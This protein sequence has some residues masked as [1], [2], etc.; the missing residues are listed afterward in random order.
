M[1]KISAFFGILLILFSFQINAQEFS[2]RIN[3]G[4]SEVDYNDEIYMVDAH[5]DTGSTLVRP[6]TGLP[7][8]Y[9][10]F[11]YSPSQQ[12]SYAIPVEDGEYTVNLHF[13]ELWFGATG[14]GIGEVGKRV[15]DVSLEGQLAE[16]NLDVFAEV[17]AEAMLMKSHM[18]TVTD[19]VLDIDFD[20]RDAVG[21]VRHPVI[22]AIEILGET[23]NEELTIDG[24]IY[25]RSAGSAPNFAGSLNDGDKIYQYEDQAFFA[26]FEAEVSSNVKS[27]HYVLV[28]PAGTEEVVRNTISEPFW[29]GENIGIHTITATPY[30]EINGGGVQGNSLT[31]TYEILDHCKAISIETFNTSSCDSSDGYAILR[32]PAGNN[33]KHGSKLDELWEYDEQLDAFKAIN[34]APGSYEII[35]DDRSSTTDLI[36]SFVIEA[37]TNCPEPNDFALRIN[38]GGSEADYS[39]ETFMADSYF[40]TGSTLVRPQTGLPEPYQSFRYSPSQQMSYDISL[41]DGEYTVNMYFAELW[42]GATGGGVGGVGSRVFDVNIEGALAEDN[43]DIFAEVGAEAMLMKSHTV[44]VTGGVLEIDFDSRDAVGGERHPVINAIEI[45]GKEQAADKRPFIFS[46]KPGFTFDGL[47]LTIPVDSQYEYNYRVDWGDGTSNEN[48]TGVISHIYESSAITYVIEISGDFPRPLLNG[49]DSCDGSVFEILQWGDQKWQNLDS[50]FSGATLRLEANDIPDLSECSSIRNMFKNSGMTGSG[51]AFIPQW[52]ISGFTDFSGLFHG[53]DFNEDI[54]G[55]DVSQITDMSF[56]FSSG[57]LGCGDGPLA[58]GGAFNQDISSWNVS[59]VINMEGMFNGSSFHQD[60]SSWNVSGVTNMRGMFAN[61]N[62]DHD[63]LPWDV[64]QVTDMGYMFSGDNYGEITIYGKETYF[65]QP[66]NNWDVS[67]VTNMNGMF[68]EAEAFNQDIG[69]WDVSNVTNMS[70][71]FDRTEA[72]NQDIGNWNVSMVTNMLRM[73]KDAVVFNQ[74]IGGWDVSKVTNMESMFNEANAFN[75][76]IGDWEV[77]NVTNMSFMFSNGSNNSGEY[78]F[79]QDIGNWDVSNVTNM[80]SMFS[81]A[82]YFNQDLG[83]WDVSNIEPG[84]FSWSRAGMQ[85]MFSDSGLSNMNYDKTLIGWSQLPSLQ[86][87]VTLDAP[88]N[89]F[90][91]AEQARQHI[92]NSYGWTITDAGIAEDC[93]NTTSFITTWKTDNEGFSEDNQITI[94]T[95]EGEIYNYRVDWGDGSTLENVTGKITHTYAI[96]GTYRITIA[97]DFPRL[98]F[99]PNS[100]AETD[101]GKLLTIEQ[102]GDLEWTSMFSAFMICYNL[103]VVATDVPNLSNVESM[104]YMFNACESLVG[105]DAFSDWDVTNVTDMNRMFEGADAFN[106]DIGDWDVSKVTDMEGMFISSKVFNQDIGDW[107]VSGV[108]DMGHMF[109]GAEDFDQDLGD[110]GVYNVEDMFAMFTNSGLSNTNYDNILIGWSILPSLQ[111]G[112]ILDAPQNQYCLGTYARNKLIDDFGWIITD[113]GQTADCPDSNGFVLRINAGGNQVDYN[114][115]TFIADTYF[116]TGSTLVRPQT[117]LPEPYQS[118]RYSPSQQMSYKIPVPDGEYLINLHFAELWF[119]ATGGGVGGVG[120]RVFDVTIEG[121]EAEDNLDVFA[122]VGAET[123]MVRAY[124]VLVI[125]GFLNIDFSSLAS[126]GGQRHPIINAIEIFADNQN[127]SGK[128]SEFTKNEDNDMIIYPNQVS[129]FAIIS[130]EKPTEVEQIYVFDVSGR[131]VRT[132]NA[133]EVTGDGV[134]KFEVNYLKSGTYFINAIDNQGVKHQKQIVIKK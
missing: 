76:D 84:Q 7:E 29:E 12:M 9:Q 6:Q 25:Y 38:T 45:L 122:A 42:F 27:V 69:D 57:T 28:G 49:V 51:M 64:S 32:D 56:L 89:Q 35:C 50:A 104:S 100:G 34:L 59:N 109:T 15:F 95:V 4:S 115:E 37:P 111:N 19:G 83:A 125:D 3:T 8:P 52:D 75:Q 31:I 73:F 116:D 67:M 24:F 133:A 98:Q 96:T 120:S 23:S 55:W 17:G 2:L 132:F 99:F 10:S 97:G 11:R 26:G 85:N 48:V 14:G 110:W 68:F 108:S 71:M 39:G 80:Y 90:C 72:F 92:I 126:D 18:V 36:K 74:N 16:D 53:T 22:N 13:A 94:P 21:G 77:S 46:I 127:F 58:L 54:S 101:Y 103:D 62:F 112:V 33:S 118:F 88:Q 129:D 20:S 60:I 47:T 93:S 5:F 124:V 70:F 107:N 1:M 65:N 113:A 43:L 105:N 41:A 30:S 40:D 117:G 91:D 63:I 106:Q 86:N 114:N 119:G 78:A 87:G 102:W 123:M 130:F 134:Y 79:N 121:F 44:T 128:S 61:S 66:L 131:L 82:E 81:G